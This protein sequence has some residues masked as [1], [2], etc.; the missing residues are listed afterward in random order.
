[1]LLAAPLYVTPL[2][3]PVKRACVK[4]VQPTACRSAPC[5]ARRACTRASA[6]AA[7]AGAVPAQ[8]GPLPGAWS[9]ATTPEER[10][11][12]LLAAVKPP[13]YSV[14]LVPVLVRLGG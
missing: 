7:S 9:L 14:A 13:I 1:M 3:A 5:R 10:K 6:A 11:R 4:G 8:P 12:L 2:S